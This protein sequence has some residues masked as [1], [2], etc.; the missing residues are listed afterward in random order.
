MWPVDG[1][2]ADRRTLW[3]T[4]RAAGWT[5]DYDRHQCLDCSPLGEILPRIRELARLQ[6]PDGV[7]G[8]RLGMSRAQVQTLRTRYGIRGRRPGRP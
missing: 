2:A 8:T 3:N 5:R 1:W 6:L 7:I 4:A